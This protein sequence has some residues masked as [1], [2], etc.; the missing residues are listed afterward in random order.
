M[1][2]SLAS[3]S[4]LRQGNAFWR[5]VGYATGFFLWESRR[6]AIINDSLQASQCLEGDNVTLEV[7]NLGT[8]DLNS[9]SLSALG[10]SLRAPRSTGPR[11]PGPII[12]SAPATLW[13]SQV[14]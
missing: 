14:G 9:P 7:L 12:G 4:S 3:G 2:L 6:K 8:G 13:P 1:S 11:R 5:G 10:K